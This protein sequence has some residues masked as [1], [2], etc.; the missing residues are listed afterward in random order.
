[1]AGFVQPV[2]TPWKLIFDY[3]K[4]YKLTSGTGHGC[5]EFTNMLYD[6]TR[7]QLECVPVDGIS[8]TLDCES[9][10]APWTFAVV[11]SSIGLAVIVIFFITAVVIAANAKKELDKVASQ[12]LAVRASMT[13]KLT[14]LS[15][16]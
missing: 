15:T 4:D 5:P 2:P 9:E 6:K 7:H 14:T 8:M 16:S 11:I 13:P 10:S 1:V 3:L 12:Y